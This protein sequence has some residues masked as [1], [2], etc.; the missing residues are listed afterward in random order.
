LPVQRVGQSWSKTS[1]R[2]DP[3]YAEKLKAHLDALHKHISRSVI[4]MTPS[5]RSISPANSRTPRFR[6][7]PFTNDVNVSNFL[8]FA[9]SSVLVKVFPVP[10]RS[11]Q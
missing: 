8:Y 7:V 11:E 5:T 3:A 4:T 1:L 6:D 2:F 9:P 10:R